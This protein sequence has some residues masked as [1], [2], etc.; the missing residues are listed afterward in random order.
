MRRILDA[1]QWQADHFEEIPV[2][3]VACLRG[4]R[5]PFPPVAAT[6]YYGSIY[7][8]VQNLLLAARAAELGAGDALVTRAV[9]ALS[10]ARNRP[11]AR[12]PPMS[13][14]TQEAVMGQP[15]PA[16]HPSVVL[17][18]HFKLVRGLLA[19][20]MVAVLALTAAVVILANDEDQVST[21]TKAVPAVHPQPLPDGTRFDGGPEEGTRGLIAQPKTQP[22]PA[23]TRFDG[24]P[25]EGTRGLIAQPKA[26][27][28]TRF[29]GGPEEGTRGPKSYYDSPAQR[30][31]YQPAP[32]DSFKERSGGPRMI[33]QG[34]GAR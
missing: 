14:T 3:V 7:P 30:S 23:G 19:I 32:A 2:L 13:N 34:P 4:W 31:S 25:E 6:S 12:S 5:I 10:P 18:S 33:P 21:A 1:V 11:P 8:S 28:G 26:P 20:A 27:A 22:L 16:Q 15:I 9:T 17:R 29:D 24:G